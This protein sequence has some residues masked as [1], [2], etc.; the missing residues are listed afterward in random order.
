MLTIY[1][2]KPKYSL[3]QTNALYT[4]PISNLTEAREAFL[5]IRDGY[6]FGAS[7][8]Q[9]SETGTVLDEDNNPIAYIS[10]NGRIWDKQYWKEQA[11]EIII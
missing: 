3:S 7:N 1:L 4:L 6:E 9:F 10:Y 11:T 5:E 2:E 8:Y